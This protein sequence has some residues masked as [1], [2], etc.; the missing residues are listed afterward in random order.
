VCEVEPVDVAVR[1]QRP[2]RKIY[3]LSEGLLEELGWP[4]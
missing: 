1:L 2:Q 3:R 4:H